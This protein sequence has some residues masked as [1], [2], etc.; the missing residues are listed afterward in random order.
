MSAVVVA[1]LRRNATS[2][3][4]VGASAARAGG[5]RV[6]VRAQARAM[7]GSWLTVVLRAP[8]LSRV[9]R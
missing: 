8:F 2:A 1:A 4:E 5:S 9:C 6:P 3:D 7:T